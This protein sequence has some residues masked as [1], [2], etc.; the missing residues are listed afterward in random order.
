MFLLNSVPPESAKDLIADVYGIFP[1]SMG[2]PDSVQLYSTSPQL[3]RCQG[4]I[5]KHFVTQEELDFHLL[6]AIRYLA[7]EHYCHA[8][9]LNLNSTLLQRSGMS[10]D[11]MACLKNSPEDFFEPKE[12]ALLRLVLDALSSPDEVDQSRIDELEAM[13][14]SQTAIFDAVAQASQMGAASL[15]FRTFTK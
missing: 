10:S 11:D 15:L 3:L 5:V 14:W 9:C 2:V 13:G 7:A 6:A 1:K 4:E 12:A 8:Y